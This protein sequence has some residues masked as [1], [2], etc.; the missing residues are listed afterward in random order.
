VQNNFDQYECSYNLKWFDS[1]V[2]VY[3]IVIRSKHSQQIILVLVQCRMQFIQIPFEIAPGINLS[4]IVFCKWFELV[5]VNLNILVLFFFFPDV[6]D[7]LL[8]R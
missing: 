7:I 2:K 6:L 5:I 1:M 8:N 3:D 4:R